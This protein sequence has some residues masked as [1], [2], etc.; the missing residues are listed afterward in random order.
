LFHLG[1]KLV[2]MNRDG[3]STYQLGLLAFANPRKEVD[4]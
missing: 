4:F 2:Q 3:K 1:I